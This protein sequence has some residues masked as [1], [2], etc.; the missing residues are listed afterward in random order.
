MRDVTVAWYYDVLATRLN[1]AGA[2][3]ALGRQEETCGN[4]VSPTRE[5][6]GAATRGE[7]PNVICAA[8]S[9]KPRPRAAKPL[10]VLEQGVV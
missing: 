9:V 1:E 3:I 6:G 7:N 8:A 2:S 4:V 5:H 10:D